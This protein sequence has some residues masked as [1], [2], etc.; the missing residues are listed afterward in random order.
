MLVGHESKRPK[1]AVKHF[2]DLKVWQ[3]AHQLFLDVLQDI[4]YFPRTAAGRV[5]Q[6][7]LLRSV[8]SISANVAEGFNARSTTEYIHYLDIARRTASESE[9]W[10]YKI[11]DAGFLKVEVAERR[12]DQCVEV[13]KMLQS[14][15]SKLEKRCIK[16]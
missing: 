16:G 9:N 14:M 6:D 5:L 15:I 8:G 12:V 1:S 13:C 7:E 11:R 3:K 10:Y 2:T 4:E